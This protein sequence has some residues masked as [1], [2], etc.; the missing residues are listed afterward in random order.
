[1]CPRRFIVSARNLPASYPRAILIRSGRRGKNQQLADPFE[2]IHRCVKFGRRVFR[3]IDATSFYRLYCLAASA[4]VVER[5][6]SMSSFGNFRLFLYGFVYILPS[7]RKNVMKQIVTI[8]NYRHICA[9]VARIYFLTIC[10]DS[11]CKPRT[12]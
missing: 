10:E 2:E 7:S 8:Y 3:A 11:L 1:M 12:F 4:G 9:F 6:I 5:R